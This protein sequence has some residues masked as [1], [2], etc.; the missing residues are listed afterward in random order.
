MNFPKYLKD[1]RFFLLF[2]TGLMSFISIVLL[3]SF[4]GENV[5]K[6]VVYINV[7][8][9][10]FAIL[11]IGIGYFYHMNFYKK[12]ERLIKSPHPD[13]LALLPEAQNY[14]QRLYLDLFEKIMDT[15]KRE[16][17]ELY[18]KKKEHEE[19]MISWVHEIKLP[20]TSSRLLIENFE[21]QPIEDIVSK[22]ED[23]LDKIEG[24]VE[25]ALFY[26]RVDSFASDYL[27]TEVDLLKVIKNSVKKYAKL[28]INK[29]I[30]LHIDDES[31]KLVHSD[32]KWLG[33]IIDQLITNALKYTDHGGR[34]LI[35]FKEDDREKRLV[36]E[37]NGIG[38]KA[39]DLQRVFERGFTGSTGRNH[40]KSTGMGLYLAKKL[41]VK[42]GHDLSIESSAGEYTR[43]T[44]HFPKIRNYYNL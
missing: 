8:C 42:L 22:L 7:S 10:F 27:I 11:Y 13:A 21:E 1:K 29:Q 43:A 37:D 25:Q 3:L 23:E 35:Y 36:I 38:I 20:I 39:E 12:I 28:F 32:Q 41:A 44:I 15:H 16:L 40:T 14:E 31:G 34:I 2:Y 30:Q 26:A 33:F 17:Q 6:T 24:Y 4:D 5:W 9:L 18:N 19:Y